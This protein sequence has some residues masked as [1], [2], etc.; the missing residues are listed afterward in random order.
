MNSGYSSVMKNMLVEEAIHEVKEEVME[1][2]LKK[3]STDKYIE[4]S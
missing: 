4:T 1:N 2:Y 3:K